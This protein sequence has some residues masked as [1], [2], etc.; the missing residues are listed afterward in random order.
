MGF[1]AWLIVG[2]ISGWLAGQIWKGG[3]FGLIGNIIVGIVGAF[4]GGW[5]ATFLGISIGGG[6]ITSII[7]AVIGA[8]VLLFIISL[9]KK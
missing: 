4:V 8:I 7:T 3:G 5:L 6:L 9:V 1:I 2:A